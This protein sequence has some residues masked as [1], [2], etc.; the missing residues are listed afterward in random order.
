MKSG[1]KKLRKCSLC[2]QTGHDKRSCTNN[3]EI[4]DLVKNHYHYNLR[5]KGEPPSLGFVTSIRNEEHY[6]DMGPYVSITWFNSGRCALV[7]ACYLRLY[8]KA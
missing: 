1:E 4:G 7:H 5:Q 3:F 6:G 2:S 8:A